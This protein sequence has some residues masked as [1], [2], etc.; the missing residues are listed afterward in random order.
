MKFD[1]QN[2]DMKDLP[3]EFAAQIVQKYLLPMFD[4]SKR[5]AVPNPG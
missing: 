3:P 1:F 5:G 4:P 2:M